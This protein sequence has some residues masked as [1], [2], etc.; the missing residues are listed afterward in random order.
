M[1]KTSAKKDAEKAE[2]KATSKAAEKA[3]RQRIA[4][5][6]REKKAAEKA[7]KKR[8]SCRDKH[9]QKSIN[10]IKRGVYEIRNQHKTMKG[11]INDLIEICRNDKRAAIIFN[12]WLKMNNIEMF[13]ESANA[14]KRNDFYFKV[15]KMLPFCRQLNGVLTFFKLKKDVE[16]SD[17]ILTAYYFEKIDESVNVDPLQQII[18]LML[19]DLTDSASAA[20]NIA[21]AKLLD[22]DNLDKIVFFNKK[23]RQ[24]FTK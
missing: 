2:A 1:K 12:R 5:E 16:K 7:E 24:A 10:E 14:V 23:T 8:A 20:K 11:V 19:S 17:E 15:K 4:Q 6:N 13:D 22:V 9:L 18:M 3:E 21:I